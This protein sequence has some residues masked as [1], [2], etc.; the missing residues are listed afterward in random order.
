MKLSVFDNDNKLAKVLTANVI[1]RHS[2]LIYVIK[3]HHISSCNSQSTHLQ[4]KQHLSELLCTGFD[5]NVSTKSYP[6][7][8]IFEECGILGCN[9][10]NF[11]RESAVSEEHIASIFRVEE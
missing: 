2:S 3:T 5:I 6:R 1:I 7:L 9:T 4:Q 11:E 10:V 8:S